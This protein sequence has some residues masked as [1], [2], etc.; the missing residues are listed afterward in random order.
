MEVTTGPGVPW[1]CSVVLVDP[2]TVE[3]ERSRLVVV[4]GTVVVAGSP[5]RVGFTGGAVVVVELVVVLVDEV[6]VVEVGGVV[7]WVD[8]GS[9]D[10][11]VVL[12]GGTVSLV[13]PVVVV[14]EVLVV[15]DDVLVL[16]DD[17]L[18]DDEV[19]AD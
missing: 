4:F 19:V 1:P 16:D 3:P 18:D 13:G 6:D 5:G 10:E 17:E 7:G 11:V 12:V 9:E 14:E 8:G 2:T 15:D